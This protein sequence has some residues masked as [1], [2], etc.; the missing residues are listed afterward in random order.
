MPFR[1]P[2]PCDSDD[3]RR[4]VARKGIDD[5]FGVVCAPQVPSQ[6]QRR[7]RRQESIFDSL[8]QDGAERPSDATNR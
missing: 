6:A 4:L 5:R 7:I 8:R 1:K 3:M 2:L